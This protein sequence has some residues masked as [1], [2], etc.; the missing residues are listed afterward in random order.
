MPH[1]NPEQID[2]QLGLQQYPHA[3][4]ELSTVHIPATQPTIGNSRVR[5]ITVSNRTPAIQDTDEEQSAK[6][7]KSEIGPT[8]V[9][10]GPILIRRKSHGVLVKLVCLDCRRDKFS[11]TQGFINH[12]RMAHKRNFA[13][14]DAAAMACGQSAQVDDAGTTK[15]AP[16]GRKSGFGPAKAS[17]VAT[18]DAPPKL[19]NGG[20]P[21]NATWYNSPLEDPEVYRM[22]DKD[23]AIDTYND[24]AAV[25]ARATEDHS[26][27][28]AA[29]L[30]EDIYDF[31]V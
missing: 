21:F 17:M 14:H 25:I 22:K 18:R 5:R 7:R 31:F 4:V 19:K 2:D 6:R 11:N 15:D 3:A 27:M 29:L 26:Q 8:R 12:C 1:P 9:N 20:L 28:K 10:G 24:P 30:R 23:Y 16:K 13:N